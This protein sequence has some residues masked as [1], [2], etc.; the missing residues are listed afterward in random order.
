[1]KREKNLFQRVASLM[2]AVVMVFS[3]IVVMP[4]DVKAD[5]TK[6]IASGGGTVAI[7]DEESAIVSGQDTVITYVATK[8]G[9]LQLT[10]SNAIKN[11]QVAQQIGHAWG[12]VTL[13]NASGTPL[14]A[15]LEYDTNSTYTG[16]YSEVYGVKKG[17]T[18]K[19]R[20]SA[21]GGVTVSA[22]FTAIKNNLNKNSSKKKAVNLKKK[23]QVDGVI[24]SGTTS[25]HWYKFKVTKAQKLN[26]G[27]TPKLTGDL[28]LTVTGPGIKKGIFQV[29][30]RYSAG[31]YNYLGSWGN[32]R[33][34]GTDGKVR[35]GTYYIQVKPTSRT[36][37][38]SYKINWK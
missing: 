25:T 16:F 22:K 5:V 20:I 9:S 7:S 24:Q 11:P 38:G 33:S 4:K 15:R 17:T 27:I 6:T 2:L 26:I 35:P 31:G 1:M 36:C 30:C 10:F 21:A 14:S 32:K 12:Y 13:C 28:K 3:V 18:Y 29:N 8:D 23:K 34:Y 19:I 37:G